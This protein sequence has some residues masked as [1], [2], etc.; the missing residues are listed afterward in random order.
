MFRRIAAA[1]LTVLSLA[2]SASASAQ[3]ASDSPFRIEWEVK[4]RF[5]LFREEKD[6]L[7]HADALSGQSILESE[8]D[9]AEQSEGRGWAR[10]M[11]GRLCIDAGGA[12]VQSCNRDGVRENYLNPA[13]YRIGF[14]L[15]GAGASICAWHFAR[16]DGSVRDVRSICDNEATSRSL[17]GLPRP[18]RSSSRA[19]T[20]RP[21]MQQR[22]SRCATS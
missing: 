10:N 5:R 12:I 21:P 18:R 8:F 9:L 6:F 16:G 2:I 15:T 14:R 17:P 1:I 13:E 3:P 19:T 7:L 11:V 4:N 20:A 22:R